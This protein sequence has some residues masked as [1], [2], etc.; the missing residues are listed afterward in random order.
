M[1]I[2]G[3]FNWFVTLYACVAIVM[4]AYMIIDLIIHA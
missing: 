3:A 2:R 4:F 1:K